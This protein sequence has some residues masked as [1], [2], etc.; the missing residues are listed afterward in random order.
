[1]VNYTC[2]TCNKEFKKKSH[3]IE[4]T[5]QKKKPCQQLLPIFTNSN[6]NLPK[7]QVLDLKNNLIDEKDQLIPFFS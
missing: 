7:L 6:K 3:F 5:V 2:P 1:M 4:H